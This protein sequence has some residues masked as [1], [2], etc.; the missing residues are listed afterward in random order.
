M[1]IL[2]NYL[3]CLNYTKQMN[4]SK[5]FFNV[6]TSLKELDYVPSNEVELK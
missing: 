4:K 2:E 6:N 5:P 1:S 3:D